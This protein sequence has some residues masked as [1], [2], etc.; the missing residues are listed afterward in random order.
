MLHR[1]LHS[2]SASRK[3]E[4]VSPASVRSIASDSTDASVNSREIAEELGVHQRLSFARVCWSR[5][6]HQH[7]V[8]EPGMQIRAGRVGPMQPK[9]LKETAT[10]ESMLRRGCGLA[11]ALLCK[12]LPGTIHARTTSL[13]PSIDSR[14]C[15]S[16]TD[17][18]DGSSSVCCSMMAAAIVVAPPRKGRWE[19]HSRR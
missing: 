6:E 14:A 15:D 17:C 8:T 7:H 16:R 19:F 11:S 4:P 2:A 10:S 3:P 12:P 18:V 1:R 9:A 13:S 5:L